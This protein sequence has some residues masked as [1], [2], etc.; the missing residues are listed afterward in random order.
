MIF[1]KYH[2]CACDVIVTDERSHAD[3]RTLC[4]RHTGAGSAMMCA[5]RENPFSARFFR[6][7]GREAMLDLSS[8]ICA[9]AH[10]SEKC[11][12]PKITIMTRGGVCEAE[13]TSRGDVTLTIPEVD[14]GK[15]KL[16][17]ADVSPPTEY[18]KLDFFGARAFCPTDDVW[19]AILFGLG[20]KMSTYRAFSSGADVDIVRL[21]GSDT[22]EVRSYERGA[23]YITSAGG[24]VVAAMALHA[25]GKCGTGIS[26]AVDSGRMSVSIG[27]KTTVTATVTKVFK[28]EL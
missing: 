10:L 1:M 16:R 26:V 21:R 19:D 18:A 2:V 7:D 9:A 14:I 3:A 25:L 5:V 28:G 8:L 23:G 17:R 6:A 22:I 13:I 12:T 15:I 24:A 4:A 27:K 11:G 20:E